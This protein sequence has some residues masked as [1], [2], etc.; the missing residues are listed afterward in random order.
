MSARSAQVRGAPKG[1]APGRWG[2]LK[3]TLRP[4]PRKQPL[5]AE[6]TAL[7]IA[8]GLAQTKFR[9]PRLR[10]DVVR[11]DALLAQ[12]RQL[13]LNHPVT[14]ICAPAGSGKTTLMVQLAT[15]EVP[16]ELAVWVAL[17]DSDNDPPRLLATLVQSLL[18]LDLAWDMDPHAL[19]ANV[20][21]SGPEAR[22]VLAGIVN[23][24]CTVSATRVLWVLD[25]LHR[26]VDTGTVGLLDSLIERL[27]EHVALVLGSRTEPALPLARLRVQGELGEIDATPLCFD[28]PTVNA[29][30]QQRWGNAPGRDVVRDTLQRTG[31]WAVGVNLLL[32]SGA[33][34]PPGRVALRHG[35]PRRALFDFLAQEVL[36]ELP[37]ALRDFAVD[38]AVLPE[39][40]PALCQ[41]VTR[42]SDSRDALDALLRRNLFLSVV[43]E[44]QP[45]LRF[46]DLF[47]DF[48][49]AQLAHKPADHVRLLHERAA[50]AEPLPER[51]IRHWLEAGRWI[52][53]TDL[54]V[55]H[56]LR[57]AGEGAYAT[58]ER[59][60][61]RL[62]AEVVAA[63]PRLA[64]L[65]TEC[66]WSRWDWEQ[67][68]LHAGPAAEGLAQ[69]GDL[70][71]QLRAQLLLA[72]ALG[73]LGHLKERET[74]TERSL[75]LDLPASDAAQFHLQ[76][77]WSDFSLG[78]C[79]Q[80]GKHLAT[81]NAL[82][83]EDPASY[84]PQVAPTINCHFGGLPGVTEAYLRFAALC[85]SVPKPAAMPWHSTP[86]V[87]GAWA[88]LWQGRRAGAT[89]ALQRAE[90]I[91]HRFGKVR[92]VL[93]DATHLQALLLAATGDFGT[94]RQVLEALL[95]DL[96][97]SDAAGLRRVWER[98]YRS[99][100][101]RTL[102]MAQDGPGLAAQATRLE[103]PLR[104]REW[105]LTMGAVDSVRGQAALLA[106]DLD[107]A[108]DLLESAVARH[109]RYPA[110]AFYADPRV[111]LAALH[112]RRNDPARAWSRVAPVLHEVMRDGTA[113]RLLLE[114][115]A[116]VERLLGL[117]PAGTPEAAQVAA[118][119][120]TL[121]GWRTA[122]AGP[123]ERA[124]PPPLAPSALKLTEREREVL[125][126]LAQGLPNKVLAR[127]LS[128]SA[129]TVKRHVA[130]I[131]DKLDCDNRGQA[132]ALWRRDTD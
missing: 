91:Q 90:L 127:K 48:L 37:P 101:A 99:V 23:A 85:D 17:D 27:P 31:G 1:M 84:A 45:V 78:H 124:D 10:R 13:T 92:Y 63:D 18:P 39:L 73:A 19:V 129:H 51:A 86:V 16:G 26:I 128:L 21:G 6:P 25:D 111:A 71:G 41:A 66:A 5:T 123:T 34:Q 122:T 87:L 68:L 50:A 62:P 80:V 9:V 12:L 113:G 47:R 81:M 132:A 15:Q 116:L 74:L 102:W 117:C 8:A 131:L 11:R 126:L 70:P 77:A 36:D 64:L 72:A 69:S 97:S 112:L 40:N 4:P 121:A 93:L 60:I 83:A 2:T 20:T 7:P 43:E 119:R 54:I 57:L 49:L 110:P 98:P 59:W 105:P 100:L 88:A 30:V 46:H 107:A 61:E 56:G 55:R 104:L 29:L 38:C 76:R 52:E 89:Q 65:R 67:V 108:Q 32:A 130:N 114:P 22:A 53:A 3:F 33:G 75:R 106:G 24:L 44:S 103:G 42:R 82:V 94:A 28:E 120:Q 14:L 95:A 118:L 35:A 125:E 96:A 109:A 79:E 58:L 115:A